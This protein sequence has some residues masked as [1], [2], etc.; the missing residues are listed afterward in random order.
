MMNKIVS[1]HDKLFKAAMS[2]L[3]VAR[4]FFEKYLPDEIKQAI[5]FEV[6]ELCSKSYID[7]NLK[8]SE[9]DVL[10]KT[11]IAKKSAYLYLLAEHQSTPD[12]L[13]P[14][15]VEKYKIDIWADVLKQTGEKNLPLIIPI[16]FYHGRDPYIYSKDI[17]DLVAAPKDLVEKTLFA[18]FYLIDTHEI[19][20]EELRKNHWF[21]IMAFF[22]KH[23]FARDFLPFLQEVLSDLQILEQEDGSNYVI[24][25]LNYLITTAEIPNIETFVETVKEG[26]SAST[27]EIIMTIEEQLIERG[28]QKGMQ[29]GILQCGHEVL[30]RQLKRKFL[31]VPENYRQRINQAN[32]TQIY[33]WS[34]NL[35]DANTLDEV[36]EV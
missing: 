20:D 15:R 28:I 11:Q 35:I 23:I 31:V 12:A 10:Y 16:V 17:R 32:E 19:S 25:L 2:D 6:L 5:N 24:I 29:K 8:L 26:L 30:M 1:P 13:M 14:F 3:R 21:G 4:D 7:E 22:M 34:E 9:S 18:P 36:F 27:G 33:D